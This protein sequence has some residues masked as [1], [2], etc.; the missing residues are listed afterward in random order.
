MTATEAGTVRGMRPDRRRGRRCGRGSIGRFPGPLRR[1]G[2]D[3]LALTALGFALMALLAAVVLLA[4]TG[5]AFPVDRQPSQVVLRDFYGLE[6]NDTVAFRWSKPEAALILPIDAPA[7]YRLTLAMQDSPLVNQPR[8]ATI[9]IDGVAVGTVQLD[10]TL[11]EYTV[12]YRIAPGGW[13]SADRLAVVD[14]RTISVELQ[15]SPFVSPDDRRELGV[16]VARIALEQPLRSALSSLLTL[17]PPNA[18]LLFAAY[19]AARGMGLGVAA[20]AGMGG[21][22]LAAYAVLALGGRTG[23]LLLA[24][25][26]VVY[27]PWLLVAVLALLALPLVPRAWRRRGWFSGGAEAW[28][29]PGSRPSVRLAAPVQRE[30]IV[31]LLLILCY[32]FF[33]QVSGWN[34]YSRYD[35]VLALVDDQTTR[36]DRYHENTGDKSFYNGHYYSDK[37]PGSALLAVPAYLLIRGLAAAAGLEQPDPAWVMQALTFVASG[38]P[39]VLLALLLLRFLRPLVGEWWALTVG[40]GYALGTI[41]LPFAT[42]YF[43]HAASAFFLFAAFSVLWR[44]RAGGAAWL[45]VWAG[46]LAGW[47]VLTEFPAL[48]GVGALLLYALA[49]SRDWRAPLLMVVGAVPAAALLLGYNWLSFGGPFSFGYANLVDETFQAGMSRGLF[50]VTRPNLAVLQ[51]I[52]LGSRG[53]LRLSPWL[54]FAPLGL[55]ALR[56]PGLRREVALCGVIVAAFLLFNAGYYDP[57]GGSTPGP[58]FLLPALPFA[59]ILVALTPRALHPSVGLQIAFSVPLFVTITATMPHA[60]RAVP[61]PLGDLWLPRLGA[62]DLAETT[63][64]LR[65]GLQGAEPLLPLGLAV[66][67]A[68]VALYAT[69]QPIPAARRLA[70]ALTVF[71]AL[72]VLGFSLPLDPRGGSSQG[73]GAASGRAGVTIAGGLSPA[74]APGG[75]RSP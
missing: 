43:G 29:R 66:V 34:E 53:L 1:V 15:T 26:P 73:A 51:T 59:A 55:W 21:A 49:V 4:P 5:L 12:E 20:A 71:L 65:W 41:A 32:G 67:V 38:V 40:V 52:L 47:A 28:T 11:R 23:A 6:R 9:W 33:R 75:S 27:R 13:D 39:T 50:G 19:G 72:L 16:I 2:A 54:A 22:V 60:L 70:K 64:G 30:I 14:R 44:A 7:G 57:L 63:A 25:Q 56:R 18:L 36:I 24:Y 74:A 58:R 42:M 37:A 35:L 10:A 69:A 68:A 17:L 62:G 3:L 48:L 8:T 46:W 45:P 31:A 61:D